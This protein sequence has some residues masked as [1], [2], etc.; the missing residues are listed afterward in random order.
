[1]LVVRL[2]FPHSVMSSTPTFGA[3]PS[4]FSW[5]VQ[6]V[7]SSCL[8]PSCTSGCV[9][10][11]A[12]LCWNTRESKHRNSCEDGSITGFE[13]SEN[14]SVFCL[15]M[16]PCLTCPCCGLTTFTMPSEEMFS[17]TPGSSIY[18]RWTWPLCKPLAFY[19]HNQKMPARLHAVLVRSIR[20]YLSKPY[21][22]LG[23]DPSW[24]L[25][26]WPP[27]SHHEGA[28]LLKTLS[29]KPSSADDHI[30][31]ANVYLDLVC[32]VMMCIACLLQYFISSQEAKF[33]KGR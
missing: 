21:L 1:M 9:H 12:H 11:S 26:N 19:E 32:L 25:H 8:L 24:V 33:L 17:C 20:A 5:M 3:S 16:R 18:W 31:T 27:I 13:L 4:P 28:G 22:F 14:F 6:S 23:L 30:S 15:L 29:G 2:M 7:L 10:L